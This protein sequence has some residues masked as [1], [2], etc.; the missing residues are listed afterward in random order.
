MFEV[1]SLTVQEETYLISKHIWY[2]VYPKLE[3][4]KSQQPADYQQ[5][6]NFAKRTLPSLSPDLRDKLSMGVNRPIIDM[7]TGQF[8]N[9]HYRLVVLSHAQPD[10]SRGSTPSSGNRGQY[11]HYQSGFFGF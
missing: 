11:H 5:L 10:V 8:I 7:H 2:D 6:V 9:E 3:K 4:L 1:M